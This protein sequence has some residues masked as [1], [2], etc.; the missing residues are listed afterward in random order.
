[1]DELNGL[2]N[3]EVIMDEANHLLDSDLSRFA[4]VYIHIAAWPNRLK[5]RKAAHKNLVATLRARG[6]HLHEATVA[7]DQDW[8]EVL[9][10]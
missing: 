8:D 4:R 2:K 5:D 7:A 3:S 9:Y 10:E 6:R 1:M